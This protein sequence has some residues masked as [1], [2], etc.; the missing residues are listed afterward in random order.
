MD[1]L[2]ITKLYNYEVKQHFIEDISDNNGTKRTL[3]FNFKRASK[4]EKHYNKD[5]YQM[6]FDEIENVLYSGKF[7]SEN[8]VRAFISNISTYV[9]WASV[10][11][12]RSSNLPKLPTESISSI[13]HKYVSKTASIY[14][15][16]DD[17]MEKYDRLNNDSDVMIIQCIFE[18]IRGQGSSEIFNIKIEDVYS[19]DD[20]YYVNLYDTEKGTERLGH[21]ISEFLYKIIFK[22]NEKDYVEDVKGRQ[23]ELMPSPYVLKKT[24]K[25]NKNNTIGERLTTTYLTNKSNYYKEV[26]ETKKFRFKDIEKSGVMHYLHEIMKDKEEKVAGVEEY[27]MISDRFNV[28]KYLHSFYE[29]EVVNY[30]MIKGLINVDFYKE[31]YGEITLL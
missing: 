8:S 24:S 21:E 11:G 2:D 9:E 4:M 31:H 10:N 23:L 22:V 12:Y 15:T 27:K 14:F 29:E 1:T 3:Y 17:L 13:A 19:K 6:T 28:G 25:G 20:K 5:L 18:G 30:T 16:Q 7:T 26:F